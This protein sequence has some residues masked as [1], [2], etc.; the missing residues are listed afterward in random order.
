MYSPTYTITHLI[1]NYIVKIELANKEIGG[2]HLPISHFQSIYEKLHSEDID[3]L[4]EMVGYS[5]GYSKS[6]DVQRGKVMPSLKPKLKIF[7]NYRSVQDF[8]DS[9]TPT[10][11]MKPS[12]DLSVHMNK[13][14]MKGLVDEW[15]TSKLRS[16]SDK[17]NE[18][19]DNWYK[20]RDFYPN[21]DPKK[22][23]DEVFHW[24]ENSSG[25]THKLI[26]LTALL[27]EFIDKAPFLAGNQ[28]TA[29][30][31]IAT[32]L[33]TYGYNPK[34]IL[35]LAKSLY[36]INED[37]VSAY[38]I[39]KNKRDITAFL[40]AFLYSLSL[41]TNQVSLLLKETL[42]NKSTNFSQ[43]NE[44]FNPRQLK[45]LEYLEV[46]GKV[47]RNEYTKLM[48][49]SFMTSFRDLQELLDK[50]YVLQ[51]GKGRGTYY[52]LPKKGNDEKR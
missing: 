21:L 51:K 42:E 35:P 3:K 44:M 33:K 52:T 7:V 27:Y 45:I 18:I 30:L 5:I 9:Y 46:E 48:G 16:F 32:L 10:S 22:H 36:F 43:M 4:G 38:K 41:T 25:R 8:I 37:I 14:V 49:V 24:V 47:T 34:N 2:I 26:Q 15:D 13:L 1:L 20:H 17:P 31:T 50:N 28:I 19:Y 29:V 6:L 11:F 39:S 40:E 23:F 12:F